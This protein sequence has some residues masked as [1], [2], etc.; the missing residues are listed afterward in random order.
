ME[1]EEEVAVTV[2]S[3][4]LDVEETHQVLQLDETFTLKVNFLRCKTLGNQVI[5]IEFVENLGI[6]VAIGL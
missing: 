3:T 6:P 2:K 5:F 4:R 1:D